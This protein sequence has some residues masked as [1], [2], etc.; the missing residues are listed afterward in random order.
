VQTVRP[1]GHHDEV[2][3][4][5]HQAI[6]DDFHRVLGRVLLKQAQIGRV[7]TR[8]EKH[9][10]AMIAPLGDVMRYARE[11]NACAPRHGR[12]L[13]TKRSRPPVE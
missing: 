1:G 13:T 3:V 7:V 11:K 10:L 4:I 8:C 9:A 12:E 6:R 5:R 2:H